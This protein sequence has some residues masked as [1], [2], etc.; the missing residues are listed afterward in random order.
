MKSRSRC[1]LV[2]AKPTILWIAKSS[3]RTSENGFGTLSVRC[4]LKARL[5]LIIMDS[6]SPKISPQ[7]SKATIVQLIL[8]KVY[9]ALW[10][11]DDTQSCSCFNSCKG[12]SIPDRGVQTKHK[13]GQP[14]SATALLIYS[15]FTAR[16]LQKGTIRYWYPRRFGW[17]RPYLLNTLLLPPKLFCTKC[18]PKRRCNLA[19]KLSQL[20]S[21]LSAVNYTG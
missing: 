16:F 7:K 8:E 2:L 10:S 1:K 11:I 12:K 18:V 3:S 4:H 13:H 5:Q 19:L 9:A 20:D 14:M 21:V 17:E 6:S 15:Y